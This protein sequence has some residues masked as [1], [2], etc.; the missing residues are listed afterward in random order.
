MT[1]TKT[2]AN[3]EATTIVLNADGSVVGQQVMERDEDSAAH[4][5]VLDEMG[6]IT[7]LATPQVLRAVFARKQSLYAAIMD[8]HDYIYLV[9]YKENNKTRQFVSD[10]MERAQKVAET[11]DSKVFAKP[12]KSGIVKL[13]DALG[14]EAE[15]ETQ[16]WQVDPSTSEHYYEVV[17]RAVHKR[18][19]RSALGKGACDRA[20][21]GGR[22][23][24]HDIL[25]TADT[26]AY[27][28]AV[29]RLSGFG[30]VS[31]D[32]I[33]AGLDGD[34]GTP[35]Y[36]PEAQALPLAPKA[37]PPESEDEVVTA[38][39]IWAEN[40]AALG[41]YA[42]TNEQG[43]KPAREM[44]AK[45]RRG[46]PRQ[47]AMLGAAGLQWS[48]RAQDGPG[49]QAFDV[50]DPRILPRDVSAVASASAETAKKTEGWDLSGK[51]DGDDVPAKE[52]AQATEATEAE[53]KPANPIPKPDARTEVV[54]TAQAR[55]VS[56]ALV[57][58]L[59]SREAAK[60][61]FSSNAHVPTTKNLRANQYVPM[62]NHIKTMKK[63]SS[64]G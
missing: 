32:E 4:M 21:R 42:P 43:T 51:P 60:E 53:S 14:I 46:D 20:E 5:R 10:N 23:S 16:G 37:L 26:R 3:T 36:V 44:R 59:G 62:M 47:A 18:T 7:P 38:T 25:T 12:K 27:N 6:I 64:N 39:R 48:G 11:C 17:Y 13:A 19:N 45:A 24:V 56:T 63:E 41:K 28:R 22:I 15:I 57:E 29:L 58:L 31:A 49:F 30:D 2:E 34:A 8:P 50:G 1:A 35:E 61:W 40:I 54:S 52:E 55:K 9:S 33:I